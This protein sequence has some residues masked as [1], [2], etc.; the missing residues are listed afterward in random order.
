MS[1]AMRHRPVLSAWNNLTTGGMSKSAD[2]AAIVKSLM[3]AAA[4]SKALQ[5]AAKRVPVG[6]LNAANLGRVPPKGAHDAFSRRH[7]SAGGQRER[8]RQ[9]H[10]DAVPG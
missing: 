3:S 1:L 8:G 6:G 5:A 9:A 2:A 7:G 10:A 4:K